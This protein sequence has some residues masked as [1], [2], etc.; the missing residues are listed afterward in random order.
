MH[1]RL[2]GSGRTLFSSIKFWHF[3]LLSTVSINWLFVLINWLTKSMK[4]ATVLKSCIVP[5]GTQYTASY[6]TTSTALKQA[7]SASE[8]H[9]FPWTLQ[10]IHFSPSSLSADGYIQSS[11]LI[12]FVKSRSF[13]NRCSCKSANRSN[14]YIFPTFI[15]FAFRALT[16]VIPIQIDWMKLRH[17]SLHLFY[18]KIS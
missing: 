13:F 1:I 10:S 8:C 3:Y 7:V 18:S 6:F 5:N 9:L 17:F 16:F 2:S 11:S 14:T 4:H 15:C 12:V